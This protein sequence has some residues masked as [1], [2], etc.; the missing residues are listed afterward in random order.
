M[1]VFFLL[2]IYARIPSDPRSL[3]PYQVHRLEDKSTNTFVR[4]PPK[5]SNIEEGTRYMDGLEFWFTFIL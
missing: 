2:H 1:T 5:I 4:Q 3:E